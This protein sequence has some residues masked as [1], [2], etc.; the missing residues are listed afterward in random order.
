M[1]DVLT[2]WH[3]T[4][5]QVETFPIERLRPF[6]FHHHAPSSVAKTGVFRQH[7]FD[8]LL[9]GALQRHDVFEPQLYIID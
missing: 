5:H 8:E 1:F 7:F 6:N 9:G 4:R 2:E 3:V